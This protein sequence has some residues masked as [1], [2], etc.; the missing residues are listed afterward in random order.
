M[1]KT[2]YIKDFILIQEACIQFRPG[3][4]AITGETGAGK[5][6]LIGA[7]G[8]ILGGRAD[9]RTVREGATKAII[10]ATCDIAAV[11]DLKELFEQNDLDYNLLT[12]IRREV[13]ATGKSRAFVNDTPVSATLLKQIGE[14]L[15]DIHSQHHNMLIGDPAFQMQVVDALAHSHELRSE[16]TKAYQLYKK[17]VQHLTQAKQQLLKEQE[18]QELFRFQYAELSDAQIKPNEDAETEER[19]HLLQHAQDIIETLSVLS[20]FNEDQPN[21]MGVVQQLVGVEKKLSALHSHFSPAEE[22]Y[23]RL[24]S[25]RIDLLDII[26]S[27]GDLLSRSDFD[28][29]DLPL[30][31]N[32]YD[33]LQGLLYKYKKNNANDLIAERDR[34]GKLLE[35]IENSDQYLQTLQNEVNTTLAQAK[36]KAQAL[37]EERAKAAEQILPN[38]HSLLAELGIAGASFRIAIEPLPE[39][40]PTGADAISF[41]FGTNKQ[42]ALRPIQEIAS[43]G[44]ISRFMLAL[45]TILSSHATLPTVIFDEIDTGVSGEVADK[46]GRVMQRLSKHLQ[47]IAITHLPQIAVQ[48][49]QQLVVSK[50]EQEQGYATTIHE[51]KENERVYEIATM[52]SGENVTDQAIENARALLAA[53]PHQNN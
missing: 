29:S 15:V 38:L 32:R 1:I 49:A 30:L 46:L 26:S 52:L 31:E 24:Q 22:F 43:G 7:I 53:T 41:L 13:T 35:N 2:L 12:T 50:Q 4:T 39:L 6:I 45:K 19:M 34:L 25:V 17:A 18:Q 51:V 44:E 9:T 28:T 21:D 3:F 10:E 5:S 14:R 16:Y 8:L 33:F 36:Q 37:T 20:A 42:A 47:V 11:A 40:S 23:E 27:A 48:A